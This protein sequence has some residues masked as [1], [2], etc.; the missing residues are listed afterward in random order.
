MYNYIKL[1]IQFNPSLKGQQPQDLL[2]FIA[3]D[4]ERHYDACREEGSGESYESLIERVEN[5]WFYIRR[6]GYKMADF[7]SWKDFWN[8][9]DKLENERIQKLKESY[10]KL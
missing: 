1:S 5:A 8:T 7:H 2:S 6:F 10:S 3:E 4:E 9:Y